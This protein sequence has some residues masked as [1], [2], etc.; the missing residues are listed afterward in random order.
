MNYDH[1]VF[2]TTQGVS[3]YI[4]DSGFLVIEQEQADHQEDDQTILIHPRDIRIFVNAIKE[5]VKGL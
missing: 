2:P 4:S 1:E 3:V 5:A